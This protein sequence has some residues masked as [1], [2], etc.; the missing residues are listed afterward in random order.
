MISAA[1]VDSTR[2]SGCSV[3]RPHASASSA[4]ATQGG[5]TLMEVLVAV[6]IFVIVGALAFG[7]YNE[8]SRQSDIVEAGA[9]RTRAVQRA[10][11]RLVQDFSM[12]EPRPVRQSLGDAVEPALRAEARS[13][14]LAELTRSSW[15]NPAGLSRS[16]LQR[17]AWRVED[18]RLR[19]EYWVVLDRTLTA[20][21][22]SAVMLDGVRRAQLRFMDA[23]LSWHEQWPPLGYSAPEAPRVRPIAVEITLELEDWGEIVRLVEVPG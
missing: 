23:N 2:Q 10:M 17:V 6:A 5:F 20:E 11:Q 21:S 12:I 7:G 22:Q 18:G 1:P 4:L 15:S 9:A 14:L 19:R 8:L 3:L 16:T 13:A